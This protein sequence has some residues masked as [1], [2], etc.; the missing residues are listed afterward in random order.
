MGLYLTRL[1]FQQ[2][3]LQVKIKMHIPFAC[4]VFTKPEDNML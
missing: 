3:H 4:K 1:Y 2:I